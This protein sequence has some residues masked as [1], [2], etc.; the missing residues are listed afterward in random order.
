MNP[1]YNI[2]NIK[3]VSFDQGERD[4]FGFDDYSEKLG[5]E[6]LPF[7]GSVSKP[8]Y[9]LFVT[10]VEDILDKKLIPWK[11]KKERREIQLRLEKLLVYCWK[12]STAK[13]ELRKANLIG[14]R[15]GLNDIDVFSS[16]GWVKQHAFKIYTDKI[17]APQTFKLYWK[18]IGEKQVPV[19]K[20]F[21]LCNHK[22]PKLKA[23]FLKELLKRLRKK[24]SLFNNH[25]FESGL[26]NKFKKELLEKIKSKSKKEYLQ[27]VTKFFEFKTFNES[28]FWDKLLENRN[29]PFTYLNDWFG[30]FV[31]AVDADVNDRP[32]KHLLWKKADTSFD[33]IPKQFH[34]VS[35]SD[36]VLK[37]RQ[38]PNKWFQFK[39]NDMRYSFF[40]EGNKPK[41][42]RIKKLW[43]IY[44][45]RQGEEEGTRFFFNYR[46]YAFL[47]LLKELQ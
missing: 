47:R 27:Y 46:H 15:F 44:K 9:F 38:K 30:K 26:K 31:S 21:I 32:D 22:Q 43:K 40:D 17:F 36:I 11:N 12:R 41:N 35:K 8:T 29:L 25:R 20:D 24:H 1:N 34:S 7:T 23:E 14:N 16:K 4:P 42:Q 37:K 6:Y 19:L 45:K 39:T 5:A 18:T 3:P 10:Y 33:K 13:E 2:F 28:R